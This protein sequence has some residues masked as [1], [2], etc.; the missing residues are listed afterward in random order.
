M[1]F[2]TGRAIAN[3]HHKTFYVLIAL[4]ALHIAAITVY[5]LRRRNLA[6][7]MVTG[8]DAALSGAAPPRFAPWWLALGLAAIAAAVAWMIGRGLRL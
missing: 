8:R 7:P 1:D 2:D 4:I 6:G 3:V 5:A